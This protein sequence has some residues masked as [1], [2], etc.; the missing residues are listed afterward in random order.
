MAKFRITYTKEV[1]VEAYDIETAKIIGKKV[2]GL[3]SAS[4]TN[5]YQLPPEPEVPKNDAVF[6]TKLERGKI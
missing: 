5:V 3:D 4:I 1:V 2:T 6:T